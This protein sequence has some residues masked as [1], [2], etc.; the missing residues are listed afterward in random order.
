M[1]GIFQK[2]RERKKVKQQKQ[3]EQ[4]AK[5]SSYDRYN[6][7]EKQFWRAKLKGNG[8][9]YLILFMEVIIFPKICSLFFF[10]YFVNRCRGMG[11]RHTRDL[12][13]STRKVVRCVG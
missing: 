7:K 3:A 6:V 9:Y 10:S 5:T 8:N 1:E 4:Q 13:G 12:R 2:E 11:Y